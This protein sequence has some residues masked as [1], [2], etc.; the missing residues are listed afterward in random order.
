MFQLVWSRCRLSILVHS[1]LDELCWIHTTSFML[2]NIKSLLY[3]LLWKQRMFKSKL[4]VWTL[5]PISVIPAPFPLTL[6]PWVIPMAL[7]CPGRSLRWSAV[8]KMQAKKIRRLH[9]WSFCLQCKW[10]HHWKEL[11]YIVN[12]H[13][14]LKTPYTLHCRPCLQPPVGHHH[15]QAWLPLV[16]SSFPTQWLIGLKG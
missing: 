8:R 10:L 6:G 3:V 15:A 16:I 14:T 11:L 4:S 7:S 12:S 5:L 2:E 13:Y 1:F 9:H